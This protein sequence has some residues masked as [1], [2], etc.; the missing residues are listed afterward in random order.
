V[1]VQT[2]LLLMV[3][4]TLAQTVSQLMALITLVQTA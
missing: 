3:Q 4:T 1:L 2:A